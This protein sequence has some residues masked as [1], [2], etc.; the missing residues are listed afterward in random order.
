LPSYELSVYVTRRLHAWPAWSP[1][2]FLRTHRGVCELSAGRVG[3]KAAWTSTP[4]SY[5]TYR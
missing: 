5:W 1:L 3:R 4:T 2:L